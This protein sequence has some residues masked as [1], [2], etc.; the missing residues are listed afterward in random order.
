MPPIIAARAARPP[1][2]APPTALPL[3]LTGCSVVVD[4]D[5]R[6]LVSSSSGGLGAG[7]G[8]TLGRGVV[9]GRDGGSEE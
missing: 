1:T 4:E 8:R 5:G 7:L 6:W 3:I 9:L 2:T